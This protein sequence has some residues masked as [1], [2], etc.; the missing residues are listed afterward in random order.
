LFSGQKNN[1]KYGINPAPKGG[2]GILG[3]DPI[4][5]DSYPE[6]IITG[7]SFA[8]HYYFAL[9]SV[10][11]KRGKYGIIHVRGN[12][13][14]SIERDHDNKRNYV[15]LSK[16]VDHY[17]NSN[18]KI[19]LL[20]FSIK[21]HPYE[22]NKLKRTLEKN[23][24]RLTGRKIE[25]V[26]IGPTPYFREGVY[27]LCIEEWFRPRSLMNLNCSPRERR[28]IIA[29]LEPYIRYLS[30]VENKYPNVDVFYPFS[31]L[32]PESSKYCSPI[33]K[34]GS[35]MFHDANHLS[36]NGS[37]KIVDPLNEFLVNILR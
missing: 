2:Q 16:V 22:F 26:I 12:G 24:Q 4:T 1:I 17:L 20:I 34:E 5:K 9:D 29:E 10:L 3:K 27:S 13:I 11:K 18:S 31:Y 19:E 37:L 33:N 30:Q 35:Y 36:V 14:E 32:C 7:D 6:A 25:L 8:G 15:Y 23:I 28:S 21:Y